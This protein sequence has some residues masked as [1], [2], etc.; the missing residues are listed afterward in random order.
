MFKGCEL[1]RAAYQGYDAL[2]RILISKG[3]DIDH[4]TIGRNT[5]LTLAATRGHVKVVEILLSSGADIEN[6]MHH[7]NVGIMQ[8]YFYSQCV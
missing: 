2:V 1:L 4:K 3:A 5:P 7:V 8:A 6:V